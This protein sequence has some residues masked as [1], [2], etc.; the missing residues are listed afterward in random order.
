[1]FRSALKNRCLIA[2]LGYYEWKTTPEAVANLF[3][4][5]NPPAKGAQSLL[6]PMP[7]MAFQFL[8]HIFLN[9][10]PDGGRQLGR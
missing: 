6:P 1:M 5:A 3:A 4:V 8:F 7:V 10:S 9:N 2:A